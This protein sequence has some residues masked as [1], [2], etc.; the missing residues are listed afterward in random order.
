M[1]EAQGVLT[2]VSVDVITLFQVKLQLPAAMLLHILLK[3]LS[4]K[5]FILAFKSN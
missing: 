4:D 2:L 3:T 5:N 1:I